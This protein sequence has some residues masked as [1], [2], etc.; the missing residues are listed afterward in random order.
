[1]KTGDLILEHERNATT[2]L[3]PNFVDMAFYGA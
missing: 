2:G 3:S 1:V